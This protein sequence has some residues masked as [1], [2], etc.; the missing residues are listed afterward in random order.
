[1]YKHSKNSVPSNAFRGVPNQPLFLR[2]LN[3]RPHVCVLLLQSNSPGS[4]TP[5]DYPAMCFPSVVTAA[6]LCCCFLHCVTASPV[7]FLPATWV[8]GSCSYVQL[9]QLGSSHSVRRA[10]LLSVRHLCYSALHSPLHC[11]MGATTGIGSLCMW[12]SS[13]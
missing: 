12:R 13:R 6:V 5:P 2:A 10:A 1:M 8:S 11:N 7:F 9:A 4:V 3:C